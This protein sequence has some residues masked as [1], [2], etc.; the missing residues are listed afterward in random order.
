MGWE[1]GDEV[2]CRHCGCFIDPTSPIM[3]LWSCSLTCGR[4]FPSLR[5]GSLS[6]VLSVIHHRQDT[7]DPTKPQRLLIRKRTIRTVRTPRPAKLV[8][9]FRV[10]GVALSD[11]RF[12]A[13]VNFGFL[14]RRDM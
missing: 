5:P 11:Q 8:Q 10:E 2:F 12:H 6:T 1:D 4:L 9:I 7:L 13:V 14:D 3:S